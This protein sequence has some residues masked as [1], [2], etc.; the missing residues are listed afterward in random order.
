VAPCP[1]LQENMG[2]TRYGRALRSDASKIQEYRTVLLP[3]S[4]L[5]PPDKKEIDEKLIIIKCDKI[6]SSFPHYASLPFEQSK[7][8]IR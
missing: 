4:R 7:A 3:G 5:P 8:G 2:T 6:D 1:Q